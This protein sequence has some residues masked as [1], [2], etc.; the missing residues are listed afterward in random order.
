MATNRVQFQRGLPMSEFFDRYGPEDKCRKA[1]E[2][3]R[4]SH[5]FVCPA[6]GGAACCV[7]ERGAMRCW[8]CA[9]CPHQ[10]S[11]ISG[12]IFQGTRLALRVW[13]QAMQLLTQSKNNVSALALRSQLGVNHHSAWLIKQK[14]MEAMHLAEDDRE[15]DGR[16]EIDDAHLGGERSGSKRGRGSENR[17]PFAAAVQTTGKDKPIVAWL[18]A[19]PHTLEEVGAFAAAHVA[20]SATVVSDGL[21]CFRAA[22]L[23]GAKHQRIVTGGGKASVDKPEFK[24]IDTLL[25]NLKTAIT[26]TYHAFDFAKYAHRYLGEFQFRFNRRFDMRTILHRLARSMLRARPTPEPVVRLAEARA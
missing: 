11:L 16:A 25:G 24:A 21:G 23:V 19:R 14:I 10:T 9:G 1:L 26:G 2:A 15:L 12:T 8:Q 5:G 22:S 7:F 20:T 13:F 4:W 18:Q 3:A 17:A 6:R